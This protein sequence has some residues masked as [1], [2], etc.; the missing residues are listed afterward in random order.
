MT[1]AQALS[2]FSDVWILPEEITAARRFPVNHTERECEAELM[3]LAK[4]ALTR[5]KASN[6][7]A[8]VVPRYAVW[9]CIAVRKRQ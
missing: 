2:C 9:F 5:I 8:N 7:T 6:Q 1:A 3:R 4:L